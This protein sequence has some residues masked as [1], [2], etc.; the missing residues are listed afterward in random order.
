MTK[1]LNR[2][3]M[4]LALYKC[5]F[6][7][8]YKIAADGKSRTNKIDKYKRAYQKDVARAIV[9]YLLSERDS[10]LFEGRTSSVEEM[11][12]WVGVCTQ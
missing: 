12:Y 3:Q 2:S 8:W 10:N 4:G 5:Y 9:Y 6:A 11:D 1:W 7:N